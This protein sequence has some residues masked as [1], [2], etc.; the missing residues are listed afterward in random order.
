MRIEKLI[1]LSYFG[2]AGLFSMTLLSGLILSNSS[3]S[4]DDSVVDDISITVPISCTLSG[5]GTNSHTATV[6][7]GT[8]Q[9]DIG[10][11]TL[12]AICNDN[13]GFSIYA[14]GYTGEVYGTTTLIGAS[15]NQTIAT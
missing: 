6:N 13:G 11:T 7:P 2:L 1:K 14:I 8:Y 3:V 10:T 4:A 12:K 15:T 5:T 9:A